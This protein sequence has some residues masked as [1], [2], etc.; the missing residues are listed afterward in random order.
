MNNEETN[1]RNSE[2]WNELCGTNIAKV[3]GVTDN[4]PQSLA[5]FDDWFFG[6]Y[7]YLPSHL[8]PIIQSRAKVLEV[9]LGYGSVATYLMM[10]GLEYV[11]LDIAKGPIE[12]ANLRAAQLGIQES[13]ARIGNVLDLTSC[14]AD[15]FDAAVA[16]GSLH[17]TGDFDTAIR[18]LVR[19]L[20]PGGMIVGMV[21][22]LFSLRN[23]MLRPKLIVREFVKNFKAGGSRV[24]ADEDLRWM[25]DHNSSGEAAPATEYF[26]RRALHK[27]LSQYGDVKIQ[28]RNLDPLPII[29]GYFPRIRILMMKTLLPRLLGLDLYFEIVKDK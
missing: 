10:H 21:Y 22:S 1:S 5:L 3:L 6:F 26:S 12:M 25:S 27:V 7:P 14:K 9:G 2:F 29:G 15:E 28:A 17:H 8:T 24:R 23:W 19:T 18:E 11:G 13:V 16:I 20:K 4:S